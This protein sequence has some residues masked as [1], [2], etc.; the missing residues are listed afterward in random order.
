MDR[1]DF[2][3][4]VARVGLLGSLAVISGLLFS[5]RQVNF[6]A[7][8]TGDFQCRNCNKLKGCELPEALSE[9][10]HGEKG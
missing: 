5:R 9:R 8:C 10:D 2:L 3:K 1:K 6:K 7:D 4:R